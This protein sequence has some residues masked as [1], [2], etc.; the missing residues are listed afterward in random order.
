MKIPKRYHLSA[1]G[2]RRISDTL[3]KRVPF[4]QSEALLEFCLFHCQMRQIFLQ[5]FHKFADAFP[6]YIVD[7]EDAFTAGIDQPLSDHGNIRIRRV[8]LCDDADKGAE[9]KGMKAC[10]EQAEGFIGSLNDR[11]HIRFKGKAGES[12]TEA[13]GFRILSRRVDGVVV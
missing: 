6:G 10:A 3:R 1:E 11:H 5:I 4:V 7:Q 13:L 8:N 9:D 12:H 2:A